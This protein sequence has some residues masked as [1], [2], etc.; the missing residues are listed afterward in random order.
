[1]TLSPDALAK[2]L[3]D[4]PAA[5]WIVVAMSA[6]TA[7]YQYPTYTPPPP[8]V[9]YVIGCG[10]LILG[11]AIGARWAF[12]VCMATLWIFPVET[13]VGIKA[14]L[15]GTTLSILHAVAAGLLAVSWRHYWK[16]PAPAA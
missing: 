9:P 8:L 2:R 10:L 7:V 4:A 16:R 6:A 11:F 1:M 13:F 15:H 12:V 3:R 14:P 5:V